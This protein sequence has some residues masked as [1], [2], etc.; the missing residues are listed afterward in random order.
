MRSISAG[1]AIGSSHSS[2]SGSTTRPGQC[3]V[4][5]RSAASNCRCRSK[6]TSRSLDCR[7]ISICGC[8]A[9]KW[10]RRGTSQAEAIDGTAL[11]V[12][13]CSARAA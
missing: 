2:N 4:P 5:S 3:P 13:T 8:A 10:P 7:L 1:L 12:S 11:I 9:T 6:S